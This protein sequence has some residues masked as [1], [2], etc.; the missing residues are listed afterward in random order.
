LVAYLQREGARHQLSPDEI[1]QVLQEAASI[2]VEGGWGFS[3]ASAAGFAPI[4]A[5]G[6][7]APPEGVGVQAVPRSA[8]ELWAERDLNKRETVQTFIERVYA[9][10]LNPGFE[11]QILGQLDPP[12]YKALSVFLTRHPTHPLADR[13]TSKRRSTQELIERLTAEYS[14]EELRKVGYAIDAKLRRAA[15]K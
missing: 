1:R 14:P 8:P 7:A 13:L 3:S 10:W 9:R 5:A 6:G 11:R 4:A 2:S 12:L 15:K